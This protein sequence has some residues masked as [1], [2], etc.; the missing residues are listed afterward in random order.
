[1][2]R[3]T[4]LILSICGLRAMGQAGHGLL[5]S[6]KGMSRLPKVPA[7]SISG[8]VKGLHPNIKLSPSHS[9]RYASSGRLSPSGS[10]ALPS[11]E[12]LG[13]LSRRDALV[14]SLAG[15]AA[16][17]PLP[18]IAS[19]DSLRTPSGLPLEDIKQ[20]NGVPCENGDK[21]VI[22]W[23]GYT[24]VPKS[25]P[26]ATPSEY[27]KMM[28]EARSPKKEYEK[29]V[30]VKATP[31]VFEPQV[32]T[33]ALGG[34]LAT[35]GVLA[36]ATG[37]WWNEVIPQK[38][39]DLMESKRSG[40]VGALLSDIKNSTDE[41]YR[42]E[43]WFFTDWLKKEKKPAAIPF[44]KK[45]K[46]NSGDNPVLVAFG[47]IM[48]LVIAASLAERPWAAKSITEFDSIEKE[49]V[50][51][52]ESLEFEIGKGTVIPAI[53]QAIIGMSEG[54]ERQ[55][56]I[57]PAA[58]SYP[59]G[60]PSTS[61][62]MR[63]LNSVLQNEDLVNKKLLLDIKLVRVDKTGQNTYNSDKVSLSE[64]ASGWELDDALLVHLNDF[65]PA[66]VLLSSLLAM[67][68]LKKW[69]NFREAV[70]KLREPLIPV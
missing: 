16:L 35:T 22:E 61:S 19:E 4:V 69:R 8:Q 47:G 43:R 23:T 66:L 10:R 64:R 49:Y 41:E 59:A 44:L 46:W 52:K 2:R 9:S 38:R 67:I 40:D 51:N 15:A 7:I 53:E 18:N 17:V 60:Q 25:S 34:M 21:C 68:S 13:R 36:G 20:G 6:S 58:L 50:G 48:S 54:G 11:D 62:G 5:P 39:G 56:V 24:I 37:I 57:E 55:L 63:A 29:Q 31:G 28:R 30:P 26:Q 33:Q 70:Q 45:A 1:M 27:D 12:V 3:I 14:A 65:S 42:L 32:P